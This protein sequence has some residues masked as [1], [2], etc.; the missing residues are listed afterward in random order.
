MDLR[1]FRQQNPEYDDMSDRELADALHQRFYSDM[2]RSQFNRQLGLD[3]EPPRTGPAA[4]AGRAIYGALEG[5]QQFLGQ[6]AQQGGLTGAAGSL[7]SDYVGLLRQFTQPPE[8]E[9]PETVAAGPSQAARQ[10]LL[11]GFGDEVTG[12]LGGAA[13]GLLYGGTGHIQDAT[14]QQREAMDMAREQRPVTTFAT[15]AAGAIAPF[16][17]TGGATSAPG[18][19]GQGA[20]A[21]SPQAAQTAGGAAVRTAGI[22]ATTGAMTGA[23]EA[24]EGNRLQGAAVGGVVGGVLSPLV[25]PA[26]G[27]L[28]RLGGAAQRAGQR[29]LGQAD[30]AIPTPRI[31][32]TSELRDASR[33]AYE[34][35]EAVGARYNPQATR[36]LVGNINSA[37]QDFGLS[38]SR[39]PRAYSMM[40]ELRE[41]GGLDLSLRELDQMR[42]V[43]RRDVASNLDRAEAS[44][45]RHMIREIDDFIQGAGA[46]RMSAGAGP[47]AAQAIRAAREAH[48]RYRKVELFEEAI[49]RATNRAST[50]G[51]GGNF[52]NALR[53]Q[54]RRLMEN[55]RTKGAF[56][57]DELR[58]M[59]RFARG[60]TGENVLRGLSSMSPVGNALSA[61]LGVGG[62]IVNPALAVLPAVGLAAQQGQQAVRRGAQRGLHERLSL[63]AEELAALQA[64][65]A[66]RALPARTTGGAAAAAGGFG[67]GRATQQ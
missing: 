38:Q 21:I 61:I 41:R 4:Q 37:M 40:Q 33:A 9:Q 27:Q 17:L 23:G 2:P 29:L 14:R 3:T 20:R 35:V 16:A 53:Q 42:Q 28:Q 10:G 62:T 26:A 22:G 47:E 66:G 45:G 32:A 18:L 50:T 59:E 65:R 34:A 57:Q 55:R 5:P 58:A 8:A 24:D 63:T 51:T 7:G 44:A 19:V 60:S 52:E 49:E 15:E 11:M 48:A 12:A 46:D 39:H 36:E 64:Q 31:P 13:R 67:A 54:V 25:G 30:E 1:S 43:I 6:M 56:T